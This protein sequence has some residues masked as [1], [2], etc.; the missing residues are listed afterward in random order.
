[1]VHRGRA[2]RGD[3][4]RVQVQLGDLRQVLQQAADAGHLPGQRLHVGGRGAAVAVQQGRAAQ[5][6]DHLAGGGGVHGRHPEGAVGQ[7]VG[8]HPAHADHDQRPEHRVGDA[9]DDDLHSGGEHALHDGAGHLGADAGGHVP[10]GVADVSGGLQAEAD[11]AD[12]ALVDGPGDLEHGGQADA[13]GGLGGGVGAGDRHGFGDVEAVAGEQAGGLLGGEP[14]AGGVGVQPFGDDRLG[15]LDVGG[16]RLGGFGG[17][18][19]APSGV[20]GGAG[21]RLDG[22]FG[23]GVAGHPAVD[24]AVVADHAGQHRLG[25]TGRGGGD[26]L[27]GLLQPGA[28][29]RGV[30]DEDR[31][32][33]RRGGERLDGGAELG[34]AGAGG[35]VDGVADGGVAGRLDQPGGQFGHRQAGR[36]AGV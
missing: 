6:A 5:L 34:G 35:Q 18:A 13:G 24:D 15:G 2:L 21:Q 28:E 4:D 29:R 11:A 3:D 26:G 23:E 7:Q 25:R 9:A 31:V 17:G 32:H 22:L 36:F 10:V 27:T 30:D 20:A 12:V 33:L 8:R 16:G 19:G 14:A 1:H